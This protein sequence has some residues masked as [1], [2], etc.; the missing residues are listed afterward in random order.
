V[1]HVKTLHLGHLAKSFALREAPTHIGSVQ[2]KS[3]KSKKADEQ[4]Q[5]HREAR[6]KNREE[7][8]DRAGGKGGAVAG[9]KM[10]RK[11]SKSAMGKA[12]WD[13][14]SGVSAFK[15]RLDFSEFDA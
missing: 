10:A 12:A 11:V 9:G 6:R 1:F 2:S 15:P 8:I 3:A 14:K 7:A 5:R 13:K 4:L